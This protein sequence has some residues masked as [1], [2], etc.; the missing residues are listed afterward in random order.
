MRLIFTIGAFFY[1]V[2]LVSAQTEQGK[3]FIGASSNINFSSM[4]TEFKSDLGDQEGSRITEFEFA[5][6]I[7]FFAGDGLLVGLEIPYHVR[8]NKDAD[9]KMNQIEVGPFAR[10]YFGKSN[11]KPYLHGG[12]GLGAAIESGESDEVDYKL[13]S[14]EIGG[15]I[16]LFINKN[17]AVDLGLGYSS[18]SMKPKNNNDTNAKLVT[19]GLAFKVGFSLFL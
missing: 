1:C 3:F 16:A 8:K 10:Y 2:G 18:S 14:Y 9:Y 7:G 4:K 13:Y 17:V 11:S 5:P 6:Q 19:S 15:G 12:V